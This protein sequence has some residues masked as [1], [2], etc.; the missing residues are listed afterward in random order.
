[1]KT[2]NYPAAHHQSIGYELV[3]AKEIINEFI[4]S[5]SHSMRGP[6][7]S[8]VGLIN[9]L[10]TEIRDGNQEPE[11]Y[12]SMIL[13]SVGELETVLKQLEVSLENSKKNFTIEPLE[14]EKMVEDVV[15]E[16]RKE[17]GFSDIVVNVHIDQS[18]YFYTDTNCFRLILL[19]LI[20]NAVNFS[21]DLKEQ[22]FIDILISA[23]KRSCSIHINDN[24]IGIAQEAQEKIFQLFYRG[25][26][27]SS[28]SGV[29]LYIVHEIVKKMGGSVLVNS[30]L[31]AGSNFFVWLPNMAA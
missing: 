26:E 19:N 5:C 23:T 1:M 17:T 16:V 24:G 2:M 6:L 28:G 9:L 8:I 7:K 3:K 11:R 20:T 29:G 22:K 21:D 13:Q 15:A 18:A 30:S 14:L 25:S 4:Y 31:Q 12:I 27:K 10:H